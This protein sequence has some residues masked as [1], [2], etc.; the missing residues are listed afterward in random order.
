MSV[1]FTN[2]RKSKR[3]EWLFAKPWMFLKGVVGYF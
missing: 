1:E 3:G 2:R